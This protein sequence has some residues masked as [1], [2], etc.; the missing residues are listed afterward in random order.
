MDRLALIAVD[1][2]RTLLL[3]DGTPAPEGSSLLRQA[4]EKGIYVI[5]ATT[6]GPL[7]IR[8]LCSLLEIDHPIVCSNGAQVWGSPDGPVW[9]H[10]SIPIDAALAMARLADEHGW[11]LSTTIGS[12]IYWRQRPGQ[13]LGEVVPN[14]T[15]V[16]TNLDGI[17]GEPVTMMVWEPEAIESLRSLCQETADQCY[18]ETY[19]RSDGSIE[20]LGVFPLRA[21]KGEGLGLVLER[22][23]IGWE[24][25]VAIGDNP[26]DLPM[27]R[28][29]GVGV[30]MGN[31]PDEVK[32]EAT[33]VA[34]TNDEEGV[35]WALAEL[36][37][38]FGSLE[39]FRSLPSDTK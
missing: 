28:K 33:L 30:A 5:L 3:S 13:P 8:P 36:L 6:R 37:P 11:E 1:L 32:R 14:R 2:D 24:E 38:D 17:V 23:E 29:A 39:D 25:V 20:C 12:M 15:V 22:L 26:N 34:P 31:A 27:I 21:D 16:P 7:S 9:A 4:A 18:T 35:A 10:H 19:F